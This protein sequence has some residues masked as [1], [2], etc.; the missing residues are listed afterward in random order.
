MKPDTLQNLDRAALWHPYTRHSAAEAGLP[1]IVRG[2]GLYLV[3]EAGRRYLD[4][5]ASWWAVSLGHGHPRLIEALVRQAGELQHS[6]LGNLSH[7]GAAALAA[8]LSERCGGRRHVLFAGDGASAVEAALK[9]A[10]QFAY[11]EGR[12]ECHEIVS[13]KEGYHGDTLGALSVGYLESFHRPF[14][15]FRFPV[16]QAEAPC[17]GTC[18]TG[19]SPDTCALTCLESF[20][21]VLEERRA[22]VA[23]VIV[24]PL[25]QGAAG[26]RMYSP[27]CLAEMA[28]LTQE[29]GALLIVD[30][31]AMGFGRTGT[32]W[33]HSQ[34]K[35][36]PDIVCLGK[37][38]TGGYLPM[39]ATVVRDTIYRTFADAPV[40]H[41][42]YHGHTFTGNPLCAAV[43]LEA[44]AI[45]DEAQIPAQ[46][47][48]RA[49]E[50]AA[51]LAPLRSLSPV[52]DVRCLG[53]IGAVEFKDT[54]GQGT[55]RAR[56]VREALLAR[57]IL[58]RPLGPVVY[59]MPPLV[60]DRGTL[61]A[62]AAALAA[63]VRE[64]C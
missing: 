33:A 41:T 36:D 43:A 5:V 50:L 61:H 13:L 17:C 30:E 9:I 10:I 3:D 19:E 38:L 12:P 21:R 26:M 39:S 49:P 25:C 15:A 64:A 54:D 63:A 20:R 1:M 47:H 28:R 32:M 29:A 45:Y 57:Q 8:Q 4:A 18:A 48:A 14:A 52:R 31:I 34:A 58:V 22:R 53:L 37:A 27:R 42:L 60:I 40:D 23:A 56:R 46:V 2:E 59:L 6:I 51:V 55:L 16:H 11:N 24:E 44:L 7:P 62:L 35:I